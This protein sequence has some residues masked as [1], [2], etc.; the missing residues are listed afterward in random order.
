MKKKAE[1]RQLRAFLKL[2]K[3]HKPPLWL[4]ALVLG[5]SIIETAA[6]LVVPIFTK[7]LVDAAGGAVFEP[8]M[9]LLL[10]G[11]FLLQSVGGGFSYYMLMY[12]GEAI[13]KG[14]RSDLWEHV[15]KLPVSYFDRHQSGETMSRITQDTNTI[16]TLITNHLVALSQES[17]ASQDP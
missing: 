6:G 3:T 16:K 9:I 11:A 5:L 4:A 13:V 2:L 15:L 10:V 12:I 1:D 8:G 17:S 14:I 7:Q